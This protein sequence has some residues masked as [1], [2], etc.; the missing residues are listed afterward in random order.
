MR[1]LKTIPKL[2]FITINFMVIV[3]MNICAYT[4][5]FPSQEY[6][7][8]SYLGLM[9]PVFLLADVLFVL[10]W[11]IFKWKLAVFPLVGMLMC[12]GSVRAYFPL[13]FP[14]SPP[15]GSLK[16]LS[17][18]VMAFGKEYSQDRER[19]P[20]LNYLLESEADILCLQEANKGLV[21][22]ALGRIMEVYPYHSLELRADNYMLCFSKY[23]ICA[24]ELIDYPTVSNYSFA[25]QVLVGNDTLLVINNHLESYQLSEEDKA[26]YKSIIKNYKHPARNGSE[27]KFLEL[28]DKLAYH[29]SIRGFQADSVAAYVERHAGQ[30]IIACGDFNASPIS[31]PHYRL[32][33]QLND[34]YTRSGNGPGLSY[35]RS[36]MYFR[37]D[38]ILTSPNISAYGAKVDTSIQES[39][40]YPIFCF[41]KLK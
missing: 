8:L 3:A 18:N 35:N 14:T 11:L 36:G 38:H 19:N 32:T 27:A 23:P 34:A 21:D 6:A 24:I 5:C 17:Y 7:H 30:H 40:H 29:D 28:V 22:K 12:A 16:I 20:I 15:E 26:D 2:I 33:R 10:F 37:L 39:D 13:N 25:Y 9:F 41:V 31:Y 4:S 1:L